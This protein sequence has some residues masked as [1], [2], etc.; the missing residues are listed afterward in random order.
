MDELSFKAKNMKQ[1][2]NILRFQT[3]TA[4]IKKHPD[5]FIII[6]SYIK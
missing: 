3:M 1:I 4:T 2:Q 6:M 5:K